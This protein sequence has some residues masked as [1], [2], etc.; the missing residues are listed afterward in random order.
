MNRPSAQDSSTRQVDL[1]ER[2]VL[3]TGAGG[4]IGSAVAQQLADAGARMLLCGRS[5]QKLE[6]TL[7][8]LPGAGDRHR[9]LAADLTT[10][11]GLAQV[12][13]TLRSLSSPLAAL[14]NCA[15]S[16]DFGL[17]AQTSAEDIERL[18]ATNLVAPMQLCR[19]A[20]PYLDTK[21]GRILNVGSTFGGIGH[22]GFA[23]Y[24]ASKFGLRGFTEALRREL[25]DSAIEVAWLAPRATRTAFNSAA[26]DDLNRALGN[27]SDPPQR[28]AAAVRAM[29]CSK[30][31]RD[32]A[33]GWPE[34]LFLRIN[35]LFPS[36]VDGALRRQLGTIRSH[37][38][39]VHAAPAAA[40]SPQ[41]T[42]KEHAL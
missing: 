34:R 30:R 5:A 17:F 20:L 4:G 8:S 10:S 14:V 35:A 2:W 27:Q 42:R 41:S 6:Q 21:A 25:A 18:V 40:Y 23:A 1:R 29:L 15:G 22:P 38:H 37:A 12:E 19:I 16:S 24:C 36:L 7:S 39:G 11:A 26:V 3:L 31:M 9:M 32:R 13:H 28:V 33:I